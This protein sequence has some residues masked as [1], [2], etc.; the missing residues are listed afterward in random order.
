MQNN[1]SFLIG[2]NYI[3]HY[4]TLTVLLNFTST[5]VSERDCPRHALSAS[6]NPEVPQKC[7]IPSPQLIPLLP[8]NNK[9]EDLLGNRPFRV[10]DKKT[11]KI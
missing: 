2:N 10:G 3:A 6:M 1:A 11:S 4:S 7:R 8:I 5:K 9:L